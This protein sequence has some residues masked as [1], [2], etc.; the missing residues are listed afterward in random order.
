[1]TMKVKKGR[2][3]DSYINMAYIADLKHHHHCKRITILS[4]IVKKHMMTVVL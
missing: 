3:E 1:M 4:I 2:R